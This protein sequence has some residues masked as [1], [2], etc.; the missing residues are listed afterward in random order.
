MAIELKKISQPEQPTNSVRSKNSNDSI[1]RVN[2]VA[3]KAL[4]NH[5]TLLTKDSASSVLQE[6]KVYLKEGNSRQQILDEQQSSLENLQ[7]DI[8]NQIYTIVHGKGTFDFGVSANH[9]WPA[10]QKEVKMEEKNA[11][12]KEVKKEEKPAST[13]AVKFDFSTDEDD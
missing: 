10:P 1:N 6:W 12:P 11:P 5:A 13:G 2:N 3:Q 4:S 8:K 9:P 7:E